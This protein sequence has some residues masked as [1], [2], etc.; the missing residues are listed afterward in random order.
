MK[1]T[2]SSK[3]QLVLP[4]E[5]RRRLRLGRGE[6]VEVEMRDGAVVLTPASR[7]RR[8]KKRRHPVSRLPVMVAAER[9]SRKVSA[10]E[11]ARLSAALL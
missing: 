7:T 6:E 1:A 2:L 4:A 10:A 9:P 8:Y 5:V 11:I 3:G